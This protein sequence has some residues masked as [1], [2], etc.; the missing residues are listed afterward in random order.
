MLSLAELVDLLDKNDVLLHDPRVLLLVHLLLLRELLSVVVETV[1]QVLPL[2]VVLVG[3]VSFIRHVVLVELLL[4]VYFV[5]L[6]NGFLEFF[7]VGEIV[8]DSII[9]VILELLFLVDLLL[10]LLL[11]LFLRHL[12]AFQFV[13]QILDNELQ[14]LIY[15]LKV[16]H[17]VLHDGLLLI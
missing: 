1:F 3:Q 15:D 6:H 14:V 4:H 12:Q 17:F 8:F 11:D 13:P 16:L 9:D 7:V 10:N 2:I 5:E